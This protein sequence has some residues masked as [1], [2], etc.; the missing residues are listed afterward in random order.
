MNKY[1]Y[2]YIWYPLTSFY[3]SQNSQIRYKIASTISP[4]FEL[5]E[6]SV[7]RIMLQ[8]EN[9]VKE[10]EVNP[11][12]RFNEIFALFNSPEK[13]NNSS[14]VDGMNNL[15]LHYLG[16]IDLYVGQNK[17]DLYVK[18]IIKN[19]EAGAFGEDTSKTFNVFK[20]YEKHM[21]AD[22]LC[23]MYKGLGMISSFKKV[24]KLIYP[25]SIIYDQT[26]SQ[27]NISVYLNYPES[28][29]NFL[30]IELL[31]EMFLPLKMKIDLFWKYHFG[32]IG[33][34]VTMRIGEISVF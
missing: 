28:R 12:I 19:I 6:E 17:K 18:E 5:N 8:A 26:S 14:I 29:E 23:E 33:Y 11:F 30:K 32:I 21:I 16:K 25:D 2:P 15:Y 31:Q 4:Y 3:E 22:I 13:D 7:N 1:N 34:E 20:E 9:E 24:V 10:F 27:K